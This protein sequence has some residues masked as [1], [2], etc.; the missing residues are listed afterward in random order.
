MNVTVFS[1]A[2]C[3]GD[4][5]AGWAGWAKSQR[6]TSRSSGKFRQPMT[7]GLASEAEAFAIIN[8]VHAAIKHGVIDY[9]DKLLLQTDNNT[10]PLILG[11]GWK[12]TLEER[13]DHLR[14]EANLSFATVLGN[15]RLSWEWRHVRGHQ[16]RE[17]TRE[18]VNEICDAEA[19]R[20][21]RS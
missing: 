6:G 13:R 4:G 15:Y 19:R 3:L 8:A 10:V 11:G 21:A 18:A 12:N 2:S 5:R 7:P 9:D 20:Q 17:T 16:G 14:R 1:D